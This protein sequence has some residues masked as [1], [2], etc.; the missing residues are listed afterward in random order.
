MS[1]R[2][3]LVTGASSGLGRE[4]TARLLDR[5]DTVV[6]SVRAPRPPP[7]WPTSTPTRSTSRYST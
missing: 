2:T 5:G 3:W 6:G 1:S 4:L 7:T